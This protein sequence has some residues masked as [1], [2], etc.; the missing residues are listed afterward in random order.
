MKQRIRVVMLAVVAMGLC[1]LTA[2]AQTQITFANSSSGSITFTGDG[3]GSVAVSTSGL[4]GTAFFDDLGTF[5]LGPASFTAGPIASELFPASGTESLVFTGTD[6]DKLTGTVTW[7]QIE[8]HT[9][10]PKFFGS[11]SGLVVTGDAA[12]VNAFSGAGSINFTTSPLSTGQFLDAVAGGTGSATAGLS[13]GAI[14]TPEPGSL[15]LLGSG[16]LSFG[17]FLRRRLLSV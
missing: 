13:N 1:S 3:A 14:V 5:S 17:G 8:D 12:F 7:N 9:T 11:I 4:S 6:A 15:L 2:A 16:L 10:Q